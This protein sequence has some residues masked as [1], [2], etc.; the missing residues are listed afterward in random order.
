MAHLERKLEAAVDEICILKSSLADALRR[1]QVCEQQISSAAGPFHINGALNQNHSLPI[2]SLI[3]K[4]PVNGSTPPTTLYSNRSA[5]ANKSNYSSQLMSGRDTKPTL[6]SNSRSNSLRSSQ[7]DLSSSSMSNNSNKRTQR[8]SVSTS[9]SSDS[10]AAAHHQKFSFNK[11]NGIVKF[12]LRGRPISLYIPQLLDQQR[13]SVSSFSFDT[14]HKIKAPTASLKLDWVYG[15]RG[16]DCRSNLF[17]L[18]SGE[19]AYFIAA[20]AVIY[21]METRTQRHYTGHN[22][23]IKSMALHPNRSVIIK[24][25]KVKF[26]EL[27]FKS[28]IF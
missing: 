20:V 23:D 2:S 11:E 8:G 13:V 24:S 22:D 18:A 27:K 7:T 6:S 12:Y 17:Q 25:L 5:G 26:N 1:L 15:Y 21:N 19:I 16:K 14:E 10:A 28:L 9:G 4:Q 3:K